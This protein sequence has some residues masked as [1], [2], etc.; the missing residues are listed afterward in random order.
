[1]N[2][3]P[4]GNRLH[5][6]IFGRRNVGKSSLIN[7]LTNQDI[8]L[9]SDVAG[10]TT[11]PV[12]KAME[13]LPIGPVLI[14]DTAGIDDV[15]VIGELRIQKTKEV[16]NKTDLALIVTDEAGGAYEEEL[17]TT[18]QEKN[19]P[20]VMV[21]NK[22]D[23]SENF[24]IEAMKNQFKLP[25]VAVS[26]KTREGIELLKETIIENAPKEVEVSLM[27]GLIKKGDLVVLV[28]P[29]DS[30]APKGRMILPQ[31]QTIRDILDHDAFM[32]VCKETDL[33][34]TLKKLNHPPDL[35]VTD[36][37]A[38]AEVSAIVPSNVPLTSFSI[39]FARHKGDLN[40]LVEGVRAI[41]SLKPGD[42]VLVAEGCTHH[43]Q[44]DDIGTVKIPRWLEN[45]VGGKLQFSYV[46]GTKFE[47]DL[48]KFKLIVH[49]GS[50]MHNRREMM[51][52]INRAKSANV[53]I[54]NY[55][56]L[57]ADVTGIL[58]RALEPFM[59]IEEV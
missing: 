13:I 48:S 41:K 27:G 38:F 9:V 17:I 33:E 42:H 7:A 3:T 25:V 23:D 51:S 4:R 59:A 49:C 22:I 20:I 47:E 37:Q 18:I 44:D 30:A 53:P 56:V 52:R 29:I 55:G 46:A 45:R 16:L 12:Y 1:M 57:I 19:I 6:A 39:L 24:D 5:I 43:R 40:E 2:Q 32:M 54:V 31:V 26:A 15:G 34:A 8:A 58:E 11:D 35:V 10:T 50:C 21:R 14:I 36:S 28:T